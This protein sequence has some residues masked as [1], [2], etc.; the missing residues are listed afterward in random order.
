MGEIVADVFIS[1]ARADEDRVKLIAQALKAQGFS[2]WFDPG[3]KDAETPHD[4]IMQQLEQAKCV[5]VVWSATSVGQRWVLMEAREGLKRRILVPVLITNVRL[6]AQFR[7][8]P[9]ENLTNWSGSPSDPNWRSFVEAVHK[10]VTEPPAKPFSFFQFIRRLFRSLMIF[11]LVAL[12]TAAVYFAG[13]IARDWW[14]IVQDWWGDFRESLQQPSDQSKGR[15]PQISN[16]S[17]VPKLILEN[18]DACPEMVKVPRGSFE[19]GEK[20][21]FLSDAMLQHEV[22]IPNSIA[23]SRYEVTRGEWYQCAEDGGC[24]QWTQRNPLWEWRERN[25]L[26]KQEGFGSKDY[27]I[28]DV[29]W[30]EAKDMFAGSPKSTKNPSDSCRKRNGNMWHVQGRRPIIISVIMMPIYATMAMAQISRSANL[31]CNNGATENAM[32]V[33]LGLPKSKCFRQTLSASTTCTA[34]SGN[35]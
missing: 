28:T 27:P 16:K 22:K 10:M 4:V 32:T 6:P 23:V 25:P 21:W 5:V 29:S 8:V 24:S 17:E 33:T 11:L 15:K 34:M 9:T 3:S 14:P 2:V 7:P 1:F 35:G 12:L 13:P 19:M 30:H 20:R 31:N 26:W 18:C